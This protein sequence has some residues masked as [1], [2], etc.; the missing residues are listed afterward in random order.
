[1]HDALLGR[2]KHMADRKTKT[3]VRHNQTSTTSTQNA[4]LAPSSVASEGTWNRSGAVLMGSRRHVGSYIGP[5]W[6]ILSDIGFHLGLSGA[7]LEPSWTLKRIHTVIGKSYVSWKTHT[8]T[9]NSC[10]SWSTRTH[11]Y[12]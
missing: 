9:G 4:R 6:A 10:V 7:L 12:W 3:E 1:M 8:V 11:N 5:S 2:S